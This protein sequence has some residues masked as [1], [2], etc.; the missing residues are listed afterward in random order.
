MEAQ[1]EAKIEAYGA[2]LHKR[3]AVVA[4]RAIGKARAEYRAARDA[5]DAPAEEE[6]AA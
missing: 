1:V 6:K 3:A 5:L 4:A 2:A